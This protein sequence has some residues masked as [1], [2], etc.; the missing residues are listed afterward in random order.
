MRSSVR[1]FLVLV[2]LAVASLPRSALA[3]D[4]LAR[5][6][7]PKA[8]EHL[9]RGNNLYDA[10]AF[11]EAI[12]EYKA[13][14]VIDPAPVFDYNLGQAHRQLGLYREALWHYDRFLHKGQPTGQLRDAVIAFMAEMRAHLENK[15]QS[16]PPTG[17]EP[18]AEGPSSSAPQV[19]PP[20]SIPAAVVRH[21][22][23][24]DD[25]WGWALSGTGVVGITVGGVLLADAA[26]INGDVNMTTNQQERDRLKEKEH[27]RNVLGV[28]VG[29]GG[30]GLLALGIV[31]LAVHPKEQ[32]SSTSWNLTV[33][34][35]GLLLFGRF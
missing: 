6:D 4:P 33:T 3:G 21:E 35:N 2:S 30:L 19:S 24:Y 26:G 12:D 22:A 28:V 23:W 18:S 25:G 8:C 1:W 13:G 5:P 32:P 34:R 14:E 7:S 29:A 31:K 10:G 27:M 20:A 15:A 16:M 17:R 9:D 11:K